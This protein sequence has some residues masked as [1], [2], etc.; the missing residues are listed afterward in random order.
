[1]IAKKDKKFE[2]DEQQDANEFIIIFLEI[3]GEDLNMVK[4]KKYEQMLWT[5]RKKSRLRRRLYSLI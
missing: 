1:M 3:L 2:G 5:R 4:K